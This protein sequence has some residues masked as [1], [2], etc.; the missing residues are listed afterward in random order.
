VRAPR[1]GRSAVEAEPGD[2]LHQLA[3]AVDE[4]GDPKPTV[5]KVDRDFAS[6]ASSQKL[7]LYHRALAGLFHSMPC[8]SRRRS[9]FPSSRRVLKKF[10]NLDKPSA[11]A[12]ASDVGDTSDRAVFFVHWQ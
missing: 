10:L 1:P 11:N 8:P 3:D 12:T 7:A 6:F 2:G 9:F 5:T 4:I